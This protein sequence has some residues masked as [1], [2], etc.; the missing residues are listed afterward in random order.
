MLPSETAVPTG[1]IARPY[2]R[3]GDARQDE[4]ADNVAMS[5]VQ[6][7]GLF[8]A[9]IPAG[10]SAAQLRRTLFEMEQRRLVGQQDDE[11][12]SRGVYKTA[13]MAKAARIP[14]Q[15]RPA[16]T[17]ATSRAKAAAAS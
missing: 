13:P 1:V 14:A 16:G 7:V 2:S 4:R 3:S 11:L 6:H 10:A 12:A 15:R 5:N 8:S 9:D 17:R